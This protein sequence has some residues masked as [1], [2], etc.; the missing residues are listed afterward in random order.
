MTS[1]HVYFH[2]RDQAAFQRQL[3]VALPT[4]VNAR[5]WL[6]RTVLHLACSALDPAATEYARMLLAHSGIS[7][8]L[9]DVESHWTPL[10]RALYNGNLSTA[11]LL[12]LRSDVD[13]TL[14]DSE[15]YRA[16]DLYNTTVEDTMPRKHG[17]TGGFELYTWGANRNASL[18]HGDT[19]DRIHPEQVVLGQCDTSEGSDKAR[20][21]INFRL[22]PAL[23]RDVRLSR[24]HTV[25]ITDEPHAKIHACGFASTGR[26]GHGGGQHTQP[27][28]SP[29]VQLSFENKVT[30]VA[31][32]QDHTLALTSH[33]A[34]FSWGLSR[35]SQLGYD[36]P[37]PHVQ[38]T[39]R[40]IGGPLKRER[41]RGIAACKSASACWT[42]TV[43]FT[44][45]KNNGQLGYDK[46]A[47]PIQPIPRIVTKV[48]KP[49]ISVALN[50]NAMAC[51]LVTQDV[52]L[53]FN[54]AYSRVT[55]PSP[56][57][58]PSDFLAYRPPQA[59]RAITTARIF[60][61]ENTFATISSAGEIFTFNVPTL[62]PPSE[63]P[64]PIQPQ[65]V[66]TL[67]K[68]WSAVHDAAL[69]GDSS[70]I[71]CT[72]SGHVFVRSRSSG[73]KAPR[74][75][76]VNGLHRVVAVRASDTGALA[77]LREPYRP[78]GV[79]PSGNT[80]TEDIA[81]SRPF[82]SFTRIEHEPTLRV[83]ETTSGPKAWEEEDGRDS[84]GEK[85]TLVDLPRS[86]SHFS[87]THAEKVRWDLEEKPESS[88]VIPATEIPSGLT[89]LEDEDEGDS[90]AEAEALARDSQEIHRL[91]A[92]LAQNQTAQKRRPG[93]LGHG[94]SVTKPV[95]S[96]RC[97]VLA[98]VLGGFGS[99]YDRESGLSLK[100]LP[101]PSPKS[102]AGPPRAVSEAPRL[103]VAGVHAF[104]VLVLVHYLYTDAL[105]AIGDPRLAGTTAEAFSRGRVSPAQVVRELRS[106]ARVLHLECLADA[107]L[108]T[109]R[110]EPSP[111]LN[112]DFRAIF[113][114]PMSA[115]P[116][117]V[118]RLADRDVL[119]HS[120]VLRARSPF[121]EVF[122]AD[123]DW[124]ADRWE[125]DGTLRVDLRHL[126]WRS[127]QYVLRFM[128][129][130]E[131]AE[132]FERL[133]FIETVD[134]LLDLLFDVMSAANELLLDRLLLICSSILVKYVTINNIS[135][136]YME[137]AS[138]HCEQLMDSLHQYMSVNMETLLEA[139]LLDDLPPRLVRQL[140]N[141]VRGYQAVKS[142]FSRMQLPVNLAAA[143]HA[144]HEWL[145][146]QDI[147]GP[148]VRSQSR[149][150]PKLSPK[151][152]RK[153]S[154]PTSPG[155]KPTLPRTP[156]LSNPGED[157]FA[158]DEALV[159]PLN[160][161][162]TA[163]TDE[164]G[165]IPKVGP[166][167][168][169]STTPK[170]DMKKILA[171]AEEM[172]AASRSQ[173]PMAGVPASVQRQRSGD[174]LRVSFSLSKTPDSPH[175][176]PLNTSRATPT[177]TPAWR[178]SAHPHSGEPSSYPPGQARAAITPPSPARTSA[179]TP[180][181]ST[182][183]TPPSQLSR[184]PMVMQRSRS[185]PGS[186]TLVPPN[187]PGLGPVISPSKSKAGPTAPRH[188]A[189]KAWTLPSAEPVS[190]QS[191]SGAPVSFAEIQQLQSRP[192]QAANEL[193]SLRDI[194]AEEAEL[195]AEA[196][197]MKWWTAEE[198][199]IRLENEA[200][201]RP[202]HQ[203]RGRRGKTPA[204]A[205]PADGG[206]PASS[207]RGQKALRGGGE[208]KRR[209]PQRATSDGKSRS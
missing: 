88:S 157:L 84:S 83:R 6:G 79:T 17:T 161:D 2:N 159:P 10:H 25:V 186:S 134:Q 135:A 169:K 197:F 201:R 64:L 87:V 102:G 93:S 112:A 124:T 66:W 89:A 104:S 177:G 190:R 111:S 24:L 45:G 140:S 117:I 42:D 127:M 126:E 22:Q 185:S 149:S 15:G 9:Q 151:A 74:F 129:C 95:L 8:N 48:T 125:A 145:A 103:G 152:S 154:L 52:V 121:F 196:E 81:R 59:A 56:T 191:S 38:T 139:R 51:L 98:R 49:V 182:Q 146:E 107:L 114:A 165:P 18:G 193:R 26:L 31:L 207:S 128:C 155:S 160:L 142:P 171:E 37:A 16:F 43:L 72:E 130:G 77:A 60:C 143:V 61:N 53:L 76:R 57:R 54:D 133:D 14:K 123:E 44:W 50:D 32:G 174:R 172:Q 178:I 40:I 113:D 71:I 94:V 97:A 205:Q 80:L 122:F 75:S 158:M 192:A 68:Q 92:F 13:T 167:K 108:G 41:A 166:W 179:R 65:R 90:S 23:A 105:L 132:M 144:H 78:P 70:L 184:S 198:E 162:A 176:S 136:V 63:R 173:P 4:D 99:L 203:R 115:T 119:S 147:P 168:G 131:E 204:N 91:W 39:P 7:P 148:I 170:I 82:I 116:D 106:L 58:P 156:L 175:S 187:R 69:A 21:T 28:L 86:R 5:D 3:A 120:F 20:D 27:S 30:A 153:L 73:S 35:F 101:G 110:R 46:S 12:L 181:A 109:V 96:A 206:V 29:I 195:Q 33:G 47:S 208:G 85:E 34:V 200:C 55:F 62:L 199:R 19:D 163:S 194:Q 189:G 11:I 137:A 180:P 36:V 209:T 202:R 150:Q 141:A 118:L 188:A 138:L 100:L 1:L 183:A 164:L 67:R